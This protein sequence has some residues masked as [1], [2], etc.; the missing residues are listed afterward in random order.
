MTTDGIREEIQLG[1]EPQDGIIPP[2]PPRPAEALPPAPGEIVL[3]LSLSL[4]EIG[5]IAASLQTCV[6]WKAVTQPSQLN[7]V[8]SILRKIHD[9]KLAWVKE[10]PE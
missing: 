10:H 9:A 6:H 1:T 3:N 8:N 7:V 4:A 2:D 5:V